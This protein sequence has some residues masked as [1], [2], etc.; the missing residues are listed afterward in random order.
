MTLPQAIDTLKLL[1]KLAKTMFKQYFFYPDRSQPPAVN[2]PG[3]E[4]FQENLE[5]KT[6]LFPSRPPAQIGPGAE[7]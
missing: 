6:E 2:G 4:K 3:A 7:I 1:M 5:E